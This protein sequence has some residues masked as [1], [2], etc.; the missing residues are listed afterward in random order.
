MWSLSVF[1]R[2]CLTEGALVE[3]KPFYYLL[4][5]LVS[6]IYFFSSGLRGIVDLHPG[7]YFISSRIMAC[8]VSTYTMQ[9]LFARLSVVGLEAIY[10][11]ICS[12]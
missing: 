2:G 9:C 5:S 12:V 1:L 10:I 4:N 8:S 3:L 11:Y 7:L 6:V